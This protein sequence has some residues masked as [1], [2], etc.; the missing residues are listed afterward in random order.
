MPYTGKVTTAGDV[1][2]I[3]NFMSP[4]KMFDYL[5]SGKILITSNIKVL[6]EILENNY[7]SIIIKKYKDVNSW[8]KQIDR[9]NLNENK[10]L[11]IRLNAIYTAKKHTWK[12]RADQML[13]NI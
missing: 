10:Y 9:I 4:M 2:N 6:K 5:G 12:N 13:K 11:S 3:I 7:N 1:S 8:K